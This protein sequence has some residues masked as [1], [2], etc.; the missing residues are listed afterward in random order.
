MSEFCG[1]KS[2]N[3]VRHFLE[4]CR[5]SAD[6]F[7]PFFPPSTIKTVKFC[8]I[9]L[10]NPQFTAVLID[11]RWLFLARSA[12]VTQAACHLTRTAYNCLTNLSTYEV[13][14]YDSNI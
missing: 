1:K 2:K 4:L 8:A 7:S 5:N 3:T 11:V 10:Y 12:T 6:H 9:A 14:N 13:T